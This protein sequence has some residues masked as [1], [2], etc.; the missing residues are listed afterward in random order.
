MNGYRVLADVVVLVH[1]AYIAFVVI[2]LAAIVI[3]LVLRRAWARNFW[4]RVS[5]LAMIGIVVFQAWVGI[6]CPLTTLE[7]RLRIAGGQEVYALGFIESWTHSIIFFRAHPW[8]FLA[9]YSSF[10]LTVLATFLIAPPGWP[11]RGSKGAA[12]V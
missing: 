2:G 9:A 1:F 3:G 8:V 4:L 6:I 7:K 10:G 12:K 11:K 5:H